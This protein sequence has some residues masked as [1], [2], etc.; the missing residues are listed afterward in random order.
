MSEAATC[1]QSQ[2]QSEQPNRRWR[3]VFSMAFAFIV[4]NTEGGPVNSLFPVIRDALG[5]SLSSHGPDAGSC[6]ACLGC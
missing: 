1:P 3:T 2:P 5:L 6:Y 4:D